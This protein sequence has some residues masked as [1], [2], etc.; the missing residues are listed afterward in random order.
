MYLFILPMKSHIYF[1]TWSIIYFA[2]IAGKPVPVTWTRL[3]QTASASDTTLEL[4]TPVTWSA[5]DH[6]VIASTG[7]HLSQNENEEREIASVSGDGLT[8]TLTGMHFA[9]HHNLN[10]HM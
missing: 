5:G 4:Q 7:D 1:E 9:L 3:A 10:L 6:I 2:S 8:L